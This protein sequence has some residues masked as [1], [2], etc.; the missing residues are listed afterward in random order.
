MKGLIVTEPNGSLS[1]KLVIIVMNSF[2]EV[3][4]NRL[5]TI[6]HSNF[7]RHLLLLPKGTVVAF[8]SCSPL[9]LNSLKSEVAHE[10]G[11]IHDL[12]SSQAEKEPWDFDDI[13]DSEGE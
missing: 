5:F 3:M 6:P 4:E 8:A 13:S 9:A 10:L 1:T 2:H 11:A 12:F 7:S